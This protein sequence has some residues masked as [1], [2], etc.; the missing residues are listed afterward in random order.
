MTTEL[1]LYLFLA[2][3]NLLAAGLCYFNLFIILDKEKYFNHMINIL[4]V[5]NIL[6]AIMNGCKAVVMIMILNF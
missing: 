6:C 1:I 3:F 4:G 2:C 5:I